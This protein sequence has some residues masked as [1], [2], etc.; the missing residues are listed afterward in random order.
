VTAMADFDY[1]IVGGGTA[2]CVL[3]ARLSEDPNVTVGLVEWGPSDEHEPRA[4]AIRRWADMLEGEYDLD[5]RSVPQQRG[6]SGIRQAR[7]RILGGCATAN[8]MI[9]WRPRVADLD[10]WVSLGAEGWGADALHPRYEQLKTPI[11]PVAA[12]DRNPFV[13]EVVSSAVSALTVPERTN[14][15]DEDV[16]EGAGFFEIGYTPETNLRS[17]TSIHYL[18][19]ILHARANLTVLLNT[20]VEEIVLDRDLRATGVRTATGAVVSAA[21]EVIVCAGAIDSPK[22]LQLS[23]IG[24]DEVL[25]DA[26]I[27]T[28]MDLPG[29]GANLMDHAEGIVVW[30]VEGPPA[31]TCATGWDAGALLRLSPDSP[32]PDI[33]MHFPVVAWVDQVVNHGVTMPPHYVAIAPNVAKPRSRG[34][35]WVTSRDPRT[36]PAIDYRYFTDSGG[37]DEA[38]LVAGVRAA[39]RIGEAEPFASRIRGEVFP[40]P[41]ARSDAEISELARATHQ[42]VYH[43]SGTCRIGGADDPCAV[44]DPRLRVRGVTGLRVVDASVFPTIP[45]VNPVITVILTAE[46]AA[47]LILAS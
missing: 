10:E 19:P 29:V 6:N 7:M 12:A 25:R 42:T 8:T 17:S 43:V 28:K 2:G 40:G 36:A 3:A 16:V 30:E 47:G 9:S 24:P 32:R 21:R 37:A 18:H 33:T 27:P 1:V 41:A 4:R 31:P 34:Q 45:S 5:Y 26:G 35:V 20:R 14:W 13:A 39:R 38:V 46:H 44:V 22:L 15:N 23:G 11:T